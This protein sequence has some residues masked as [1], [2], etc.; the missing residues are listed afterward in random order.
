M[1]DFSRARLVASDVDALAEAIGIRYPQW[2]NRCHEVSLKLIRTGEFGRARVARG[3]CPG[4]NSQHS[5]IVV[6]WDC[7]DPDAV[8]VDPTLWSYVPGADPILVV[9]AGDAKHT[10]HGAGDIYT[11]G[12]PVHGGGPD[13]ELTPAAPLSGPA[14]MFLSQVEPLDCRGWRT[15]AHSPVGGWPA[16]EI[17]A[18]MLDTAE[19][20]VLVPID[21]A[22]MVTDRNPKG[23]Y[24]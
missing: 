21:I 3:F 23:L 4:V 2:A 5:W 8:I 16:A 7:Y 20:A 13:I 19:L 17:I 1:T 18:A 22:G 24:W 12:R 6:G 9:R 11:G 15:L 10:P 14:R